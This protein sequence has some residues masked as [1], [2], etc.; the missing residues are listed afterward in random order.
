MPYK[1]DIVFCTKKFRTVDP[2]PPTVQDKVLKKHFFYTFPEDTSG[3]ED[4][5][6][7][8]DDEDGEDDKEMSR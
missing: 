5:E 4:D 2:H 7:N 3:D 8:Q 6:D 1:Y